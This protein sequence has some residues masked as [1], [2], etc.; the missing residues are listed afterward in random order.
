METLGTTKVSVIGE[1]K[2]KTGASG[3]QIG[4]ENQNV[5]VAYLEKL[6]CGLSLTWNKKR[7][8]SM[9]FNW[10]ENRKQRQYVL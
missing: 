10:T 5:A 3:V 1:F 6:E 7:I 2:H 9:Y 8:C 4:I